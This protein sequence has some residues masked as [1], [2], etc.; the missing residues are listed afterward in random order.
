M[1]ANVRKTVG[2][3]GVEPVMEVASAT[4]A[5]MLVISLVNVQMDLVVEAVEGAEALGAHLSVTSAK[6]SV[7]VCILSVEVYQFKST[8]LLP[9]QI[10]SGSI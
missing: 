6:D 7:S 1:P 10:H 8:G 3:G 5:T 2:L 9:F 4:I